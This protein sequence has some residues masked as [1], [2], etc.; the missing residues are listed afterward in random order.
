MHKP[1]IRFSDPSSPFDGMRNEACPMSALN[2]LARTGTK[3]YLDTIAPHLVQRYLDEGAEGATSNPSI[4]AELVASGDYDALLVDLLRQSSEDRDVAWA[5]ADF[6]AVG[7][8]QEF[9]TIWENSEYNEG[10]VSFEVDPM[11]ESEEYDMAIDERVEAYVDQAKRAR[12]SGSPN[13]MIKIPA[14]QAGLL[15][16]TPLAASGIP[17]NV[18]LI[19]TPNQYEM[20][21]AAIAEGLESNSNPRDFKSVYSVFVSR[22]EQYAKVHLPYLSAEATSRLPIANAKQ[23]WLMNQDFW[24]KHPMRL[25]QEIVFAS[26]GTKNPDDRK[27]KYVAALAGSDIQT[28][29]P[30][31]LA[32]IEE[33]SPSFRRKIDETENHEVIEEI[34]RTL[35]LSHMHRTLLRE[36]M[37][38]FMEAQ[39]NLESTIAQLRS[40]SNPIKLLPKKS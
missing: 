40:K 34:E 16:L 23:I 10:W 11:I 37:E 18:T 29:P 28:I 1:A 12:E 14:T 5:F 24:G 20:A 31:T 19:F 6:L 30:N 9:M 4:I 15:A 35:D 38:K 13:R 32:A 33:A 8:E 26:I 22:I 27:W 36:G 21:R 17:L 39:R 2:Q 3:I 7:A 25:D